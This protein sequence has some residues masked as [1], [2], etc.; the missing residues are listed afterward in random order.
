MQSGLASA[1]AGLCKAQADMQE[2]GQLFTAA[3]QNQLDALAPSAARAMSSL[4]EAPAQ[5][6]QAAAASKYLRGL[7]L[8]SIAYSRLGEDMA[9]MRCF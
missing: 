1:S 7:R 5:V 8:Q 2:A 9:A 3:F 6:G 4:K